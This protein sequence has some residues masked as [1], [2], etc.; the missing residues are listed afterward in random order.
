MQA[1]KYAQ[2]SATVMA[3]VFQDCLDY[4]EGVSHQLELYHHQ[5]GQPRSQQLLHGDKHEPEAGDQPQTGMIHNA[6]VD[7]LKEEADFFHNLLEYA[8]PFLRDVTKSLQKFQTDASSKVLLAAKKSFFNWRT[9]QEN[10]EKYFRQEFKKGDIP[11]EVNNR[12]NILG[13]EHKI[14]WLENL[15]IGAMMHM[16]PTRYKDY[17][18]KRDLSYEI[19]REHLQ[20]KVSDNIP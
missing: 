18:S 2:E 16:K 14:E 20:E 12:R 3:T 15:N 17:A 11:E 19:T 8:V 4:A 6:K 1:L 13:V 7:D 5:H 9:I 10:N